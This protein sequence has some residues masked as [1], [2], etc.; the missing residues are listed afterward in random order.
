MKNLTE[1]LKCSGHCYTDKICCFLVNILWQIK[2]A[3]V[4]AQDAALNFLGTNLNPVKKPPTTQPLH[5]SGGRQGGCWALL[6]P[7]HGQSWNS[8]VDPGAGSSFSMHRGKVLSGTGI[9]GIARTTGLTAKQLWGWGFQVLGFLNPQFC[10]VGIMGILA[11]LALNQ[12]PLPMYCRNSALETGESGSQLN[13][14]LF[15]VF[16]VIF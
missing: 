5:P 8:A 10:S 3:R 16:T 1:T 15:S 13:P 12:K 4:T 11:D 2:N 6:F 7:Y 14:K 9:L